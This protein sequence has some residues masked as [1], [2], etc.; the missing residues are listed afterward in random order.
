MIPRAGRRRKSLAM[1]DGGMTGN[2]S[3]LA[4]HVRYSLSGADRACGAA[5]GRQ[6]RKGELL[7]SE[8]V[9]A[10][11]REHPIP[12]MRELTR[13]SRGQASKASAASSARTL[14]RCITDS[15][16]IS[17]AETSCGSRQRTA[18]RGTPLPR[19]T[20]TR[21]QGACAG[22]SLGHELCSRRGRRSARGDWCGKA[23]SRRLEDLPPS[24]WS[25][26]PCI[27][28]WHLRLRVVDTST[29]DARRARREAW[30]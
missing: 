7:E 30:T 12:S 11:P 23:R 8:G 22:R 4:R 16:C 14:S 9:H 26:G 17:T 29:E 2:L 18:A 15:T 27:R 28:R 19:M 3:H 21:S 25:G 6:W 1:M 10:L 13:F 5:S 20:L 24:V